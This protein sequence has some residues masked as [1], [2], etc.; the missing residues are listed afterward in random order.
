MKPAG[1][2]TYAGT[3]TDPQDDKTYSGTAKLAGSS[4]ELTGC[5]MSVFCRTQTWKKK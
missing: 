2:G 4:L 5:A 1:D 3:I